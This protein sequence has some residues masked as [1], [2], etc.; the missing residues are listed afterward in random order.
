MS[1]GPATTSTIVNHVHEIWR[2]ILA[3]VGHEM[4]TRAIQG[5]SPLALHA[6]DR[7][8]ADGL[9]KRHLYLGKT[10]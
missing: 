4:P 5:S 2:S 7:R 1:I 3:P 8:I 9:A 6:R 10:V